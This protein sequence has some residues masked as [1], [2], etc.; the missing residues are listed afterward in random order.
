MKDAYGGRRFLLSL[1]SGLV[2][3]LMQ[4][5]DKLDPSGNAYAAI[6]IATVASYITGNVVERKN[7]EFNRT[8]Q[9]GRNDYQPDSRAQRHQQRSDRGGSSEFDQDSRGNGRGPS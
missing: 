4:W 9:S 1:M 7:N 5:F 2:A 6:V 8:F 3:T